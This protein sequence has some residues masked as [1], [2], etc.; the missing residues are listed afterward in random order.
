MRTKP[1]PEGDNAKRNARLIA[2]FGPAG[3][4]LAKSAYGLLRHPK[5]KLSA[6]SAL[7][8]LSRTACRETGAPPFDGGDW[9]RRFQSLVLT[10][11]D[12]RAMTLARSFY[13]C[14]LR[15]VKAAGG[16]A[17]DALCPPED[18]NAP[19][20]LCAVKNDL[21]RI[22][23]LFAH[24]RALGVGRFAMVDNGS[25]DGT[26]EF[27]LAQPDAD[28][29]RTDAGFGS[30]QKAGWL[31]RAAA[32]YGTDRWFLWIDADELLVYPGMETRGLCALTKALEARGEY[33]MRTFMLDLYPDGPLM[34]QARRDADFLRDSRFFDADSD[35]YVLEPEIMRLSGGMRGRV[36]G[37]PG[38]T[39]SK[40]T[41]LH[42]G[43]GRMLAGAH[44]IHPQ[45]W[46]YTG[47][48]LGA[49]L[50]Y[51]F[52]PRDLQ[53]YRRI[54]AEG[55]YANGSAEYRAY[56]A[57]FSENPQLCAVW[58]NSAAYRDSASLSAFPFVRNPFG[59]QGDCAGLQCPVRT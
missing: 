25:D 18:R 3:F 40:V 46:D 51:K 2:R 28:V 34:D 29:F 43:G 30:V 55:A 21:V 31:D 20:L 53:K 47:E 17:G 1:L 56:L 33:R 59:D 22:R 50:H 26:L 49:L 7:R 39:L 24:Y 11:N 36:F 45:H 27:L 48:I 38:I 54:A 41:L 8:R 6:L 42:F 10:T 37:L 19:I 13:G 52:L 5:E 14:G 57:A 35:D 23:A 16:G 12:S 44:N 9:Q 58:E 32:G 4:R 15:L